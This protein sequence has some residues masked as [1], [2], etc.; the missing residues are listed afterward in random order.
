MNFMQKASDVPYHFNQTDFTN[1]LP[2]NINLNNQNLLVKDPLISPTQ[3]INIEESP[4]GKSKLTDNDSI[5]QDYIKDSGIINQIANAEKD[6]N[7]SSS[8]QFSGFKPNINPVEV[9]RK[10]KVI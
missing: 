2:K 10:E 5:I 8:K 9:E 7:R 3:N 1:Y 4:Y 6:S